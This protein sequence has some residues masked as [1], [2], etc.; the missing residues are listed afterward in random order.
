VRNRVA[1]IV[2]HNNF[3][4][5][6]SLHIALF[7]LLVLLEQTNNLGRALAARPPHVNKGNTDDCNNPREPL[8]GEVLDTDCPWDTDRAQDNGNGPLCSVY[9]AGL[10]T[11]WPTAN[12]DD[13]DLQTDDHEHNADE[14]PVAK[15][16]LKHIDL[17]IE[18][19]VIEDVED[20]HPDEDI[21]DEGVELELLVGIRE[22]VA[23]DVATSEVEH[24]DNGELVD[25]LTGDLLPHGR[26][27]E[28][29]VATLR[30]AV[31]DLV[32][33]RIGSE[34]EGGER[35]HDQVDPKKLNG[36]ENGLHLVVVHRCNESEN[37]GRDIDGDLELCGSAYAT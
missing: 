11:K 27:D 14:E 3:R 10:D 2:H 26:G 34:G 1:I 8:V 7:T 19:S 25:V 29:L 31:Q 18:A 37:D 30:W 17:V 28:G 35:V 36:S 9:T 16:A 13:Q 15:Y 33:R 32:G 23:E 12:E 22:I 5:N 20:L 24:E 21:E 4:R 6:P